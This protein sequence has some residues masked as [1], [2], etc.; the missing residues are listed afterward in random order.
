MANNDKKVSSLLSW[1]R[2]DD[3]VPPYELEQRRL[4]EERQRREDEE[5]INSRGSPS[6]RG[7]YNPSPFEQTPPEEEGFLAQQTRRGGTMVDAAQAGLQSTVGGQLG[8]M[9]GQGREY[10]DVPL[11]SPFGAASALGNNLVKGLRDISPTYREAYDTAAAKVAELGGSLMDDADTNQKLVQ[12][13]GQDLDWLSQGVNDVLSSP[14]SVASVF[15]GPA[16]AIGATDVLGQEYTRARRAG[17]NQ[18]DA[19]ARA[20][21]AAGVEFGTSVIP[22][23]KLL[24]KIPGVKKSLEDVVQSTAS[25]FVKRTA[26]QMAGEGLQ[27]GTATLMQM[28]VDADLA[29]NAQNEETREY[30]AN[31]LP[32]NTVDFFNTMRRS[33]I[34][35]SIGGGVLGSIETRESIIS[36]AGKL[37]SDMYLGDLKYGQEKRAPAELAKQLESAVVPT[38]SPQ[39]D[40]FP[41]TTPGA[42]SPLPAEP[43]VAPAVAAERIPKQGKLS[44]NRPY[45]P[46]AGR[47]AAEAAAAVVPIEVQPINTIVAKPVKKI[48]DQQRDTYKTLYPELKTDDE[49]AAAI[50]KDKSGGDTVEALKKRVGLPM[51]TDAAKSGVT[52]EQVVDNIAKNLGKEKTNALAKLIGDGKLVLDNADTIPVDGAGVYDPKTGRV[53]INT[54]QLDP[55]NITGSILEQVAGHEFD[56]AA[57]TSKNP[58]IK[59][60]LGDLFSEPATK[61]LVSDVQKMANGKN[62]ADKK[63]AENVLKQAQEGS[64]PETFDREVAGYAVSEALKKRQTGSTAVIARTGVS[65]LRT[66]AKRALPGVT[67]DLN[68]RDLAYLSDKLVSSAARTDKSLAGTTAEDPLAMVMGETTPGFAQAEKDGRVYTDPVDGK[69]KYVTSDAAARVSVGA[70]QYQTLAKGEPVKVSDIL[71]HPELFEQYPSLREATVEMGSDRKEGGASYSEDS[72]KV[73]LGKSVVDGLRA[74]S[75]A[76]KGVL[77]HELQHGVQAVEDFARGGNPDQFMT[78][79]DRRV[80]SSAEFAEG[81]LMK[82]REALPAIIGLADVPDTT[83]TMV[84]G[85]LSDIKSGALSVKEGFDEILELLDAVPTRGDLDD[86]KIRTELLMEQATLAGPKRTEAKQKAYQKYLSLRGEQEARF[87]QQNVDRNLKDIPDIQDWLSKQDEPRLSK[88]P[89]DIKEGSE[90]APLPMKL[91]EVTDLVSKPNVNT[92]AGKAMQI[93]K[94]QLLYHSGLGKELFER[95][96]LSTGEASRDAQRGL[97]AGANVDQGIKRLAKSEGKTVEETRTMVE[98]RMDALANLPTPEAR[99]RALA[100]LVRQYPNLRSLAQAYSDIDQLTKTMVAQMLRANPTPTDAD[101]KFMNKILNNSFGYTTRMYAAFQGEAGSAYAKKLMDD[102]NKAQKKIAKDK[103]LNAAQQKALERV[104]NAVRYIAKHD[105]TIPSAEKINNTSLDQIKYLYDQWIGD[106]DLAYKLAKDAAKKDGV[107]ASGVQSAAQDKLI[108]ALLAFAPS[109][110]T[111]SI[112]AKAKEAVDSMLKLGDNTG[113]VPKYLRTASADRGILQKREELP[114]PIREL[115]G[116]IK[117]PGTRVQAT[118]AKQGELVARNKFLLYMK[119]HGEGKWVVPPQALADGKF[120]STLDGDGFGAL[121]GWKTTPQIAGIIKDQ[122]GMFSSTADAMAQGFAGA[123]AQQAAWY[124]TADD[125]VKKGASAAK[126]ASII[127]EGFNTLANATGSFATFVANG[128]PVEQFYSGSRQS[129]ELIINE[130]TGNKGKLSD[131]VLDAIAHGVTDSAKVNELKQ[132]AQEQVRDSLTGKGPVTQAGKLWNTGKKVGT[133]IF[134]QSDVWPKLAAY[135]HRKNVLRK[136]Y[137]AAGVEMSDEDIAA[138]AATMIKDTNISSDRVPPILKSIEA[139]GITRFMPYFWNVP[140]SLVMSAGHGA[141]DLVRAVQAPT[142]EA[143]LVLGME[144]IRRLTGTGA[145]TYGLMVGLKGLASA[146]NGEDEDEVEDIKKVLSPEARYGD[147]IYLGKDDTGAPLFFRLSRVD[148]YGPV[149]DLARMLM[150]PDTKPEDMQRMT[151]QYVKDLAFANTYTK[152]VMDAMSD[153]IGDGK[154]KDKLVRVE[155]IMPRATSYLKDAMRAFEVKESLVEGAVGLIDTQLPGQIDMFDPRNKSL[156]DAKNDESQITAD[157]V[158]YS[159]GRLDRADPGLRAYMLGKELKE[160]RDEARKLAKE[161]QKADRPEAALKEARKADQDIYYTMTQLHDVYDGMVDG[162]KMSPRQAQAALKDAGLTA[163]DVGMVVR[164]RTPSE[165]QELKPG[166]ISRIFSKSSD[167]MRDKND[168]KMLSK[169]DRAAALAERKKYIRGLTE[170]GATTSK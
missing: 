127:M 134:A 105:L 112:Q 45:Q 85:V 87:V 77:L 10:Q 126:V 147:L 90:E 97:N 19:M 149:T 5:R 8:L 94:A 4:Q 170:A 117:D 84:R 27:E 50:E 168:N 155:R 53:H 11:T 29:R 164:G 64:T 79:A 26:N 6:V 103:N 65:A 14:S 81:T 62:P 150:D 34:A 28:G 57:R 83:R 130:L 120:T 159:G 139:R 63:W 135:K 55:K 68:V 38:A 121:K 72:N 116:E 123:D 125:W 129:M 106:A 113:S 70:D 154:M 110:D 109:I 47:R 124:R 88:K 95:L 24:T 115:L 80:I 131:D 69:K 66:W 78:D 49:I 151:T 163:A 41:E 96:K 73:M 1:N 145:A 118:I 58:D 15:G 21:L 122:L 148:P 108:E 158:K 86:W 99:E 153:A 93:A 25:K 152:V 144:G 9:E 111:A 23:G 167:E 17:V 43:E 18:N 132:Q 36:D 75:M 67:N 114:L 16:A 146:I 60:S 59:R 104:D 32:K 13:N 92:K 74:G 136:Y 141:A 82:Q 140:R 52:P 22:T 7:R 102:Y 31:Q 46:V 157:I 128:A 3:W 76:S 137:D 71:K 119:E 20:E 165:M 2:G 56:H 98:K 42:Y 30:A 89:G 101:I 40:L 54:S 142:P 51:Q 39:L 33:V 162:L 166:T 169:E 44:L 61:K 161:Y 100:S 35:G 12:Q 156:T 143:K 48:T 37:A 138:E 91:S 133:E 107:D 160:R